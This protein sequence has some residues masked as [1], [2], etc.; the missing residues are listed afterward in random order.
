MGLQ[1]W[2][3]NIHICLAAARKRQKRSVQGGRALRAL[4]PQMCRLLVSTH[5]LRHRTVT[6]PLHGLLQTDTNLL[7]PVLR[8]GWMRTVSHPEVCSCG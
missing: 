5:P 2:C 6:V 4:V 8:S 7:C 3:A 1:N